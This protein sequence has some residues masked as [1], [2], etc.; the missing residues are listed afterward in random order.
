MNTIENKKRTRSLNNN[1][2]IMRTGFGPICNYRHDTI[3][4]NNNNNK[5]NTDVI[6]FYDIKNHNWKEYFYYFIHSLRKMIIS[7]L[8]D[9]SCRNKLIKTYNVYQLFL[10]PVKYD[11]EK[12]IY[13]KKI[14]N[15]DDKL[16]KY[17]Y[18]IFMYDDLLFHIPFLKT[19]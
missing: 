19:K 14:N 4:N 3:Y 15:R 17:N 8:F 12:I 10:N 13:I 9:I 16:E 6:T 11:Y 2:T 5:N 7:K 1:P 18:I